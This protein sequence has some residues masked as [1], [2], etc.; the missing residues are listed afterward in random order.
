MLAT[1]TAR[2]NV[3]SRVSTNAWTSTLSIIAP[4][5]TSNL[6]V[7]PCSPNRERGS[8]REWAEETQ[9]GLGRSSPCLFPFRASCRHAQQVTR[10]MNRLGIFYVRTGNSINLIMQCVQ[11]PRGIRY[12]TVVVLIPSS[13]LPKALLEI[14]GFRM[15][16]RLGIPHIFE[17]L[18]LLDFRM[19]L[20]YIILLNSSV[21]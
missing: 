5:T 6:N 17:T 13:G 10:R 9:K 4:R 7:G 15:E 14:E 19:M 16:G 20:Q 2:V 3:D 8:S 21:W 11:Q 1:A 12:I 18:R